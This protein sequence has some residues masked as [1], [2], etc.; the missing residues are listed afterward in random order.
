MQMRC[1]KEE[2]KRS[3]SPC[4]TFCRIA[5][6]TIDYQRGLTNSYTRAHHNKVRIL[7][8]V[9]CV[10]V[11]YPEDGS[12]E[13]T[14][15]GQGEAIPFTQRFD[16]VVGADG[17]RSAIR[18]EAEART[19]GM[20]KSERESVRS[21]KLPERNEFVYRTLPLDLRPQYAHVHSCGRG[22]G[23]SIRRFTCVCMY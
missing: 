16:W 7:H 14:L 15:Q 10:G 18:G 12:V 9:D 6:A 5:I 17:V 4:S 3:V 21:V 13:L 2:Q 20:G 19:R 23:R 8:N 1:S 11:S 22:E